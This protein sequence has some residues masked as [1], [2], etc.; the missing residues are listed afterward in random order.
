MPD[1]VRFHLDEHID[2]D[3]A[4][5]LRAHGIDVTT[6]LEQGLGASD[7]NEHSRRAQQERRVIVTDDSDFLRIASTTFDH[8][9]IVYCRRT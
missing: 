3:I 8:L 4:L 6:T 1:A 5:A 7:D 9:G 2:P